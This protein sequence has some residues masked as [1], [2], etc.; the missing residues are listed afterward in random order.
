[1]VSALCTPAPDRPRSP[2]AARDREYSQNHVREWIAR[3][4]TAFHT[5]QAGHFRNDRAPTRSRKRKLALGDT[6]PNGTI[7]TC[8]PTCGRD[9]TRI[10]GPV[11]ICAAITTH[12]TEADLL[13][14]FVC[15]REESS[16][17]S[18]RSRACRDA[19]HQCAQFWHAMQSF[20]TMPDNRAPR[21]VPGCPLPGEARSGENFAPRTPA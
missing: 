7:R 4:F 14:F 8:A 10:T 13:D 9:P 18:S 1:M 16:S 11:L 2:S 21:A 17:C 3:S 19:R 12:A 20:M 15:C 5:R 6:V